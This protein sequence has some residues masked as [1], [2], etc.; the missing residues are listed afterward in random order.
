MALRLPC[1]TVVRVKGSGR[2]DL[3]ARRLRCRLLGA[4]LGLCWCLLGARLLLSRGLRLGSRSLARTHHRRPHGVQPGVLR[5]RLQTLVGLLTWQRERPGFRRTS[6][7]ADVHARRQGFAL[8]FRPL[9]LS[10]AGKQHRGD[11]H[12]GTQAKN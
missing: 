3:L 10:T 12:T 2:D 7:R 5:S 11:D 1:R 8:V 6:R 9:P 4:G